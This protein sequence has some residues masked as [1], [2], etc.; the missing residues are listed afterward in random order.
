MGLVDQCA[1]PR[2][3]QINRKYKGQEPCH[4]NESCFP[5]PLKLTLIWWKSG[6]GPWNVIAR[7]NNPRGLRCSTLPQVLDEEITRIASSF[8]SRQSPPSRAVLPYQITPSS[9]ARYHTTTNQISLSFSATRRLWALFDNC[10][11]TFW[12]TLASVEGGTFFRLTAFRLDRG[13]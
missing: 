2:L 1:S 7:R 5:S 6:N 10:G 8:T 3:T 12:R 4:G 9:H 13:V 11:P